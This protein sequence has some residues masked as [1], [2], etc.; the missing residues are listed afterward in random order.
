MRLFS[1]LRR[2]SV[3]L[4]D[5]GARVV[6]GACVRYAGSELPVVVYTTRRPIEIKEGEEHAEA[7]LRALQA[8]VDA[9]DLEG[10]AELVRVTGDQSLDAVVVSVDAPWQE[11]EVRVESIVREAPFTYTK[12]L[13]R[14]VI[15]RVPAAP[16][17][18][19]YTD[20]SIVGTALNGYTLRDPYGKR[21]GSA[22]VTLVTSAM[23]EEVLG[24]VRSITGR[25]TDG[26]RV[27][28]VAG[29][30]LRYQAVRVV[31]RHE[32]DL[33]VVDATGPL[34]EV[35][36]IRKGVL[37]AV[38][39]TPESLAAEGIRAEDLM[40]GFADV[41]RQYPLARTILLLARFDEADLM[42]ITLDQV[43]FSALWL[44]D[45]L[46]KVL[47]VLTSHMQGLVRQTTTN[48]PDL[49]LLLMSLYYRYLQEPLRN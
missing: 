16:A 29:T 19:A 18:R 39:E 37:A 17:S 33:L 30:S 22:A 2:E 48:P 24:R 43:P 25:L 5:I 34:P 13:E 26:A 40:R 27:A 46:P 20:V 49:P 41:S 11:T 8:V 9:L 36:L 35:A 12:A 32:P 44:S 38:S 23:E 15:A 45:T 21:A 3:A 6:A 10:V 14:E 1:R 28:I 7:M 4:V 31:F 42:R 47:T